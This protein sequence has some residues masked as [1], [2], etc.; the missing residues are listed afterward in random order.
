MC[1]E[2]LSRAQASLVSACVS[3]QRW[4]SAPTL[5]PPAQSFSGGAEQDCPSAVSQHLHQQLWPSSKPPSVVRVLAPTHMQQEN[6]GGWPEA[7]AMVALAEQDAAVP[8]SV[9]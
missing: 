8:F 6:S 2:V 3:G 5:G 1:D 7:R 9:Q 4:N